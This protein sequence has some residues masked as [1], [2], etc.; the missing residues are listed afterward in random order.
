MSA[1]S[2]IG[3]SSTAWFTLV[4]ALVYAV[5]QKHGIELPWELL[6][7]GVAAYG[8]K[9]AARHR[10]GP[11]ATLSVSAPFVPPPSNSAPLGTR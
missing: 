7:G 2:R 11:S 10:A 1:F 9:E 8:V 5:A 3:A 4:L 6:T